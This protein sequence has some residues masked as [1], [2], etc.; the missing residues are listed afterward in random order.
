[1]TQTKDIL[2]ESRFG[3]GLNYL[4]KGHNFNVKAMFEMV[5]KTQKGIATAGTPYPEFSKGYAM[6][7]LQGQWMFF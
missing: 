7:T 4:P 5:S 2:S 3:V 6:F 1:M